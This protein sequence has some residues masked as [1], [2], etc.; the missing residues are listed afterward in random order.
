M[1]FALSFL[2]TCALVITLAFVFQP[3]EKRPD[4]EASDSNSAIQV[5]PETTP[6]PPSSPAIRDKAD[7]EKAAPNRYTR[8]AAPGDP[9]VRK[10]PPLWCGRGQVVGD[11]TKDP[12][13]STPRPR[14]KTRPLWRAQGRELKP[15]ER[16]QTLSAIAHVRC[17]SSA[18]AILIVNRRNVRRR[19]GRAIGFP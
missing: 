4:S 14:K 16:H 12:E 11:D 10:M 8:S 15:A 2:L 9:V 5:K 7:P 18:L 3:T 19:L 17:V 6:I 1:I 13:M